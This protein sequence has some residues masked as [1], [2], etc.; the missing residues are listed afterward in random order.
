MVTVVREHRSVNFL[1]RHSHTKLVCVAL[2]AVLGVAGLMSGSAGAA[3]SPTTKKKLAA[4]KSTTRKRTATRKAVTTRRV[5]TTRQ[6]VTT[7]SAAATPSTVAPTSAAPV[8]SAATTVAPTTT[9]STVGPT[10]AVS[11][12][13]VAS[14]SPVGFELPTYTVTM[15]SGTNL[16]TSFFLR[17]DNGFTDTVE[18][19]LPTPPVGLTVKFD[20]NPTRNFVTMAIQSSSNSQPVTQ[21]QVEAFGS[22]NPTVLL[23]RTNVIVFVNGTTAPAG[24][25]DVASGDPNAAPAILVGL[26]PSS[27]TVVR[28]GDA[29]TAEVTFVRQ[30]GFSGPIQLQV[31]GG[32]PKE[33]FTSFKFQDAFGNGNFFFVSAGL[34]APVGTFNITID[35]VSSL[36]RRSISAQVTVR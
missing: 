16:L 27:L 8:T 19:R 1:R 7:R 12:R 11:N 32:V 26:A 34:G 6:P 13:P 25:I 24:P 23:A 20:P 17:V 22:S 31:V 10:I 29:A 9:G 21:F 15:P 14:G 33:L 18:L 4:T 3:S 30:G 2:S 36:G 35:V 5:V 28:G